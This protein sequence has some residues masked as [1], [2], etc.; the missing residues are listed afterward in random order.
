MTDRSDVVPRRG[1]VLIVDDEPL[2]AHALERLLRP[3][4]VVTVADSGPAALALLAAGEEHDVILCDVIMPGMDGVGFYDAV[5]RAHAEH[6]E[7][8]VFMTGGMLMPETRRLV[9][10]VGN[11]VLEKPFGSGEVLEIVRARVLARRAGEA[12]SASG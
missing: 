6:A 10:R 7:R 8:I 1:H 3:D 5:R 9:R 12:D 2:V 4:F 11:L